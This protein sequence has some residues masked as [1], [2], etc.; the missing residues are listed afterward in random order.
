[1]KDP[2]EALESMAK[3]FRQRGGVYGDIRRV[4]EVM[5]V[6]FPKGILLQGSSE[7]NQ[8]WIFAMI[9]TKVTRLAATELCHQD[10][11]HD[12][13]VYAA[14]GESAGQLE[15]EPPFVGPT[16]EERDCHGRCKDD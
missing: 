13:S 12:L 11:W 4:G 9:I 7:F 15:E 2:A 6:L 3:T 16:K 5:K 1:M 14:M 10:S 8:F